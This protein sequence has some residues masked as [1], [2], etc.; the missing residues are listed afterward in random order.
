M[1]SLFPYVVMGALFVA[2]TRLVDRQQQYNRLERTP[3]KQASPHNVFT[4]NTSVPK[5]QLTNSPE[6]PNLSNERTLK[7]TPM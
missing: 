6:K 7:N 2:G 4:A 3:T 1:K 5:M